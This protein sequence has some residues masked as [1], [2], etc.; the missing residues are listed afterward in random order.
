M[1]V[2]ILCG[3]KIVFYEYQPEQIEETEALT[4]SELERALGIDL[5]LAFFQ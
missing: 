3:L 5:T 4:H 1:R 2:I